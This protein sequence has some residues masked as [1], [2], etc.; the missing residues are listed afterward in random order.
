MRVTALAI[1]LSGAL[2][3][4]CGTEPE[5]PAGEAAPAPEYPA[6]AAGTA[7]PDVIVAERGGFIPEGVEYDRTNDRILTGSLSEGSVLQLH[8]DGRVTT[9]VT[10]EDLVSSVG[11][12][13]DELRNR[14]L[15][16]NS[17]RTVFEGTSAGQA[18]LAVYDLTSGDRIALIDLAATVSDPDATHL[19]NDAAVSDDGTVYVTDTMFNAIYRVT[20][21]YEASLLHKFEDTA[22]GPN[23]IEVHPDGYLLVAR[24]AELWKVPMS[25]P[26]AS[27][28]VSLAEPVPGGDGI[29][30]SAGR[31]VIVSNSD[32]RVVALTSTDDWTTAEVA[33][34][35]TFDTAATTAAVVDDEVYVVHPVFEGDD[36]PSVSRVTFH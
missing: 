25:D 3:T 6:E 20:P 26:G 30:W 22:G 11:I 13:V 4:G 16:A 29:V 2:V 27:A 28:S 12:E 17:D 34:V 5:P 7:L 15:V 18:E 36:P 35:A 14:L 19:A 31:L 8:P 32:S 33:G 10:D 23:G 9:V 24:G 21:E 1:V